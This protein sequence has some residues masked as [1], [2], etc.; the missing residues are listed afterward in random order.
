MIYRILNE[1]GVELDVYSCNAHRCMQAVML[2]EYLEDNDYA[3]VGTTPNSAFTEIAV[4]VR[5]TA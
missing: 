4:T 2:E 1:N 5:P 3:I